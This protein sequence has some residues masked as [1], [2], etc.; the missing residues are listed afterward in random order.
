MAE[1]TTLNQRI[2]T[3]KKVLLN[4]LDAVNPHT[5]SRIGEHSQTNPTDDQLVSSCW[6]VVQNVFPH[7]TWNDFCRALDVSYHIQHRIKG[8][9]C[10]NLGDKISQYLAVVEYARDCEPVRLDNL[11]IGTL[12]GGSCLMKLFALNDVGIP[13]KVVCIDPMSG[14]Y[15]RKTD[16][17]SGLPVTPE[18]F[19]ENIEGFGFST[20]RVEL[21]TCRSDA[22]DALSGLEEFHFG[23]VMI[24]GDHSYEG[25]QN[26]W[27]LYSELVAERGLILI[28]D[29][30]EEAW[31]HITIFVNEFLDNEDRIW[32][33]RGLI[34]T[35]LIFGRG[36]R[37]GQGQPLDLSSD[38]M[39]VEQVLSR[40][41]TGALHRDVMLNDLRQLGEQELSQ[42]LGKVYLALA[43]KS[44]K[45]KRYLDCEGWLQRL[46][47]SEDPTPEQTFE[48]YLQL[49]VCQM[50]SGRPNEAIANLETALSQRSLT[51]DDLFKATLEIGAAFVQIKENAKAEVLYLRCLQTLEVGAQQAYDLYV[52][53]GTLHW[54][55]NRAEPAE[56]FYRLALAVE[57]IAEARRFHPLMG[58]GKA[59]AS[60][61][62]YADAE[63]MFAAASAIQD[64]DEGNRS[65]ALSEMKKCHMGRKKG[66][67]SPSIRSE[68][69]YASV[70]EYNRFLVELPTVTFMSGDLKNFQRPW[71]VDRIMKRVPSGGTLLEIG[72]DKCELANF[73]QQR[74]YHVWVVDI[75]DEFGGGT[76][77][78]EDVT[79]QFPS[80]NIVKGYFDASPSIPVNY[81]DAVYSCSVIEHMPLERIEPTF[82]KTHRCL[83]KGGCSI[84][85]IDFTVDGPILNNHVLI[86]E[87]L[88]CH[89][90]ELSAQEV[91]RRALEDVE[92]FYLSPAGHFNWRKFLG[93]SYSEY[94]FRKVTSFN[95]ISRRVE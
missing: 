3:N 32:R 49:G 35:T 58:L 36:D 72:G 63:R 44:L 50:L 62:R 88:R 27:H 46:L 57:G 1:E 70:C 43:K 69:A 94:P 66:K 39:L 52:R 65:S 26:D 6:R 33:R 82:E 34:G 40:G 85:A 55:E 20:E 78:F 37:P 56:R 60:R 71:V 42:R 12:F 47:R 91:A 10:G 87:V 67:Q 21:R 89:R 45:E 9:H 77:R 8:R 74:G 18:I 25:I 22:V 19:F 80:I 28:D 13:G 92:T 7:A 29:Y 30:A 24:D 79:K 76:A 73:L 83:V 15:G 41:K 86:D 11:E 2:R 4:E 90:L 54:S 93:K 31:P 23:S 64:L 59:L 81:F 84:H 48:S 61:Q 95:I 68:I 75:Y 53:L 38:R 16:F 51:A 14:F 17:I 5:I